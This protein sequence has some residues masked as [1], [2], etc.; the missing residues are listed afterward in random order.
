LSASLATSPLAANT[1]GRRGSP[2]ANVGASATTAVALA[3]ELGVDEGDVER[4]IHDHGKARGAASVR[5]MV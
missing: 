2:D 3:V 4:G 1:L 5:S